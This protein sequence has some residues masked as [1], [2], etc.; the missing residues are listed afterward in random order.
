MCVWIYRGIGGIAPGAPGPGVPRRTCF[1]WLFCI[2][3]MLARSV[4]KMIGANNTM[5]LVKRIH[6]AEQDK[7]Y[8]VTMLLD[9]KLTRLP[10]TLRTGSGNCNE[11][12][13]FDVITNTLLT[14]SGHSPSLSIRKVSRGASRQ[15]PK[16]ENKQVKLELDQLRISFTL[17]SS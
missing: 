13:I 11:S 15:A 3:S 5:L 4:S 14:E 1:C 9:V 12:W 6:E 17:T 16:S 10:V 2:S 7:L 8:N